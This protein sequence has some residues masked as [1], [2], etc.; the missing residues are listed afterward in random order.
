M[1]ENPVVVFESVSKIYQVGEVSIPALQ[2]I[3]LR[4]DRGRFS[5]VLGPSGSGK[6]ILL[7]LIGC[8]DQPTEGTIQVCGQKVAEISHMFHS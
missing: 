1:A 6:T 8:L 4:I 5:M 7:N 3:S 2:G